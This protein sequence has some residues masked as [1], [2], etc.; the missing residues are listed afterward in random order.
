VPKDAILDTGMR[1][2]VYLDLGD[3]SYL[4]REVKIGPEAT[5]YLD[6]QKLKFYPVTSGLKEGDTVVTK[7]N[8]LIDS[9]S[10]IT[11]I[12]AAVYG[13]ALGTE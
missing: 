11:G 9:Q 2:I 1:K 10:Q 8:F 6:G 7:A 4:G 5:A 3:G 12:E 13:G